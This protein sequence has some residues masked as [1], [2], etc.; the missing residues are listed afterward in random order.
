[1]IDQILQHV[2]FEWALSEQRLRLEGPTVPGLFPSTPIFNVGIVGVDGKLI[3]NT[4]PVSSE[5][6]SD[7]MYY[8]FQRAQVTDTLYVGAAAR[9]RSTGRSV[10]HFSRR[11]TNTG[12]TFGG[13]VRAAVAP[14]YLTANYDR[15]SLGTNGLLSIL[16]SD[17]AI[18][19]SRIGDT[20][21]ES[22]TSPFTVAA[23]VAPGLRNRLLDRPGAAC[24]LMAPRGS[25][26]GVIVTSAGSRSRD[27]RSLP[28]PRSTSRRRLLPSRKSG[29][30][31]SSGQ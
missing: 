22:Y 16:G 19:A 11:F 23:L 29:Q 12:G 18:R 5:D 24:S 14:T 25:T 2:R 31:F 9:G 20:V 3:T 4:L 17:G 10:V 15:V 13:V 21:Y 28:L 27:I 26:T 30:I 6:V 8:R 7:R 1:M